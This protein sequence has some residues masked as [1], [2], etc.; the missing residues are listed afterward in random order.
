MSETPGVEMSTGALGH[1]LSVALGMALAARVQKKS[2]WS[3]VMFGEGCLDEGQT[4]EAML[5][6]AKFRPERLVALIDYN[7]VQLD[8]LES[9]NHAVRAISRKI[10][11]IPLE[12]RSKSLRWTQH[13]GDS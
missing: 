6:A 9:R 13:P 5:A 4:W 10:S 2:F 3:Y 8:G 11:C 12:H 1:G 7:G